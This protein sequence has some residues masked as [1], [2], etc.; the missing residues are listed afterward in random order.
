MAAVPRLSRAHSQMAV[1]NPTEAED[2]LHHGKQVKV[3][4]LSNAVL[5]KPEELQSLIKKMTLE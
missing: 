2:A 3:E 1:G 4:N 5:I